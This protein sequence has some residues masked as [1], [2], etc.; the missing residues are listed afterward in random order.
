MKAALNGVLNFSVLDGWWSEG[1]VDGET[2]WAIG[3]GTDGTSAEHDA[4]L[5][6]D[7][8]DKTVLELYHTDQ[9]RWV[10]MMKQAISRLGSYFNRHRM[11]RRYAAEDYLR[12]EPA[13]AIGQEQE[14]RDLPPVPVHDQRAGQ[15]REAPR[16]A[17]A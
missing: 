5:L 11:I 9:D 1:C 14:R 4:G 12:Q 3:D 7:K 17:V 6:Y 15:R 13:S 10:W 8:L 2:G 16:A